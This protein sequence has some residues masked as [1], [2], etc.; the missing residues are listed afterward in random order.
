MKG[1]S[2]ALEAIAQSISEYDL[3]NQILNGIGPEYDPVHTSIMNRNSLVTFEHLFGQLLA[4]ELRLELHHC[5][6]IV[7][8]PIQKV[9]DVAKINVVPIYK[10]RIIVVDLLL[11]NN[12]SCQSHV[13][14]VISVIELDI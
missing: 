2:D 8:Q 3:C 1:I 5:T 7:E 9:V 14:Y 13:P 10:I 11:L 4:F 12:L 6:L